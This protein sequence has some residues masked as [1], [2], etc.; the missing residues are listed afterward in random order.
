MYNLKNAKLIEHVKQYALQYGNF[1]LSS[2]AMSN[3]FV[4]MSKVTNRSDCLDI[5]TQTILFWLEKQNWTCDAVGGPV[6]GAA[7]MVGGVLAAFHRHHY[8]MSLIHGFLVRKEEKNGELIEGI[9][10]PGDN[11][12]I[13]EDVVTTGQQTKRAVDIVE[14]AGGKVMGI[15]AILDRLNGAEYLLGDRFHS[16]MTIDDLGVNNG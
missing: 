5:I 11:V 15:I 10:C 12:L 13:V 16:M 6:L 7:P 14:S 4:D 8:S 3:Y 1:K 2:G 9:L